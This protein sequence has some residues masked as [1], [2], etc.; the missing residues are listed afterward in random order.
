MHITSVYPSKPG[1]GDTSRPTPILYNTPGGNYVPQIQFVCACA[2]LVRYYIVFG[3]APLLLPP[4]PSPHT[5]THTHSCTMQGGGHR[6]FGRGGGGREEWGGK[7]REIVM[8]IRLADIVLLLLL[9]Y[10]YGHKPETAKSNFYIKIYNTRLPDTPK[11]RR[12]MTRS[13]GLGTYFGLTVTCA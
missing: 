2:V 1:P 8:K 3:P 4:P 7:D 9:L 12:V 6:K 11:T 5:H 10:V 13:Y